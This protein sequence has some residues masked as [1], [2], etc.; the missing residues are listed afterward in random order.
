MEKVSWKTI[1]ELT[2]KNV[3][4][5]EG[6]SSKPPRLTSRAIVINEEGKCAVLYAKKHNLYSLP[7]GGIESGED[8]VTA[9][10]REVEE[11]TGCTCDSIQQLGVVSENRGHQDYTT[12]SYY[13]VVHT[14]A[15][16]HALCLTEAEEQDG[17]SV[18]WCSV[19]EVLH[20]IKDVEHDT[21]QRKFLQA[22]D[23][24]ALMEY[25]KEN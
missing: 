19:E 15:K 3:L 24:A 25:L 8:E 6:R 7:G 23:V 22:R 10:I 17:I 13:F 14:K 2:D 21:N 9:L 12:L 1:A 16:S 4:G 18:M 5:L 20:L 11:E